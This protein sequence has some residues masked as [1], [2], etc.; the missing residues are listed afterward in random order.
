MNDILPLESI[1]KMS[2]VQVVVNPEIAGIRCKIFFKCLKKVHFFSAGRAWEPALA[3]F[4][5]AP[6]FFP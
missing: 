2:L 6:V 3:F 1:I 5:V 4:L